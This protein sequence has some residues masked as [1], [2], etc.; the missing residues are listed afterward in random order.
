MVKKDKE[1]EEIKGE[2]DKVFRE[3]K[4]KR[5]VKENKEVEIL[6]KN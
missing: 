6:N 2:R 3:D 5:R 1:S 4:K